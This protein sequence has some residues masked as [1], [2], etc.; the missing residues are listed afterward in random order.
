MQIKP[1]GVLMDSWMV[2]LREMSNHFSV[3][4]WNADNASGRRDEIRLR[5]EIN[6]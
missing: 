4:S 2:C 3:R 1:R 6:L 5:E